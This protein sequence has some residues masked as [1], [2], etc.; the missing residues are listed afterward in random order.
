MGIWTRPRLIATLDTWYVD[1]Y[2]YEGPACYELIVAGP[3]GG[4]LCEKYIG[5]TDNERRRLQTYARYGSH[6]KELIEDALQNGNRLYYRAHA[7][8]T[9]ELAKR[10][11]DKMLALYNY[12]WNKMLNGDRF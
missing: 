2:D 3:R 6:L 7:H 9:K 1:A 5:E 4:N 8:P 10:M 12:P 11:Q